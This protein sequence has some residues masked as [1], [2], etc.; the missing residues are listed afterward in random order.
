M[1]PLVMLKPTQNRNVDYAK[2]MLDILAP[3]A[4]TFSLD[5][6]PVSI[7]D[8]NLTITLPCWRQSAITGSQQSGRKSGEEFRKEDYRVE[9]SRP[10]ESRYFTTWEDY[11]A[12]NPD[13]SEHGK[14]KLQALEERLFNY[15][16]WLLM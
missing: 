11:K 16:M 9:P 10:L 1:Y 6:G 5:K 15:L 14:D 7:S 8:L 2:K 12:I 13:I 3:A 4:S